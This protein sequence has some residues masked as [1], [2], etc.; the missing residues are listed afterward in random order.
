MALQRTASDSTKEREDVELAREREASQSRR[1]AY[2]YS[3]RHSLCCSMCRPGDSPRL[4]KRDRI[5][6]WTKISV[7]VYKFFWRTVSKR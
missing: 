1:E 4:E 7:I 3:N 5:E 6:K 2:L